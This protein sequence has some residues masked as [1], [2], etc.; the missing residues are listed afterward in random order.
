ML[1]GHLGFA[2]APTLRTPALMQHP[3]RHLHRERGQL[4]H[5]MGVVRRGQGKRCVAARTPLGAQLVDRRGRDKRLTMARMARFPTR[6]PGRSGTL[7][8]LLVR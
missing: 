3:V 7:A 8:R 6:F 5:L 2:P 1:G 4:Q